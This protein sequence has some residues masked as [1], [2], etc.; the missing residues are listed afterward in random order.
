M[1]ICQVCKKEPATIHLTDIHNNIK[2]EVHLCENCAKE[3][4]FNIQTAANLPQLL[5]LAAKKKMESPR[6]PRPVEEDLVCPVCGFKWS[7]FKNKGR[8]GCPNDY[9]AFGLK[10]HNLVASQLTPPST[11]EDTFHVGKVPSGQTPVVDPVLAARRD[12]ERRLRI[13]VAGERYEEA[14]GLKAELD[15]MLAGEPITE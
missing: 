12:L 4:G 2:K 10:M 14:A 13:A 8:L 3:K 11:P 1:Y 9:Q 6:Q 15:K 5:G 7:D